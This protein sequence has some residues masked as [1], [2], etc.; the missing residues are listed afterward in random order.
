M[1]TQRKKRLCMQELYAVPQLTMQWQNWP[2]SSPALR[3]V[4][5]S[6]TWQGKEAKSVAWPL[7]PVYTGIKMCFGQLD[8]KQTCPFTPVDLSSL[9]CPLSTTS[10][11]ISSSRVFSDLSVK[12]KINLHNLH[13]IFSALTTARTTL[14]VLIA[15]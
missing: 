1:P 8:H 6:L 13:I 5:T 3:G 9:F 14:S 4:Y 7:G 2:I 11:R 10:V 12:D 15:Q